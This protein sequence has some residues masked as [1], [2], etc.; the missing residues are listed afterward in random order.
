[1]P[2]TKPNGKLAIAVRGFK[3]FQDRDDA[4]RRLEAAVAPI[5]GPIA[6]TWNGKPE[7]K[8]GVDSEAVPFDKTLDF[9]VAVKSTLGQACR[10][11]LT[12]T[13]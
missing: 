4:Q 2:E 9:V 7:D 1:M 3:T 12:H 6:I 11:K 8:A 10:V 5:V 13:F